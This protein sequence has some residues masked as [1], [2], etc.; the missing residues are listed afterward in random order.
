MKWIWK[1]YVMYVL[2]YIVLVKLVLVNVMNVELVL[3]YFYYT[4]IPA[5]IYAIKALPLLYRDFW[6][7]YY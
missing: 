7:L 5:F 2:V 1:L 3:I 4:I 6:E